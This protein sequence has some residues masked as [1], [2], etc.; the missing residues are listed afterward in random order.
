MSRKVAR[1]SPSGQLISK[2][3]VRYLKRI[4]SDV[5]QN[6]LPPSLEPRR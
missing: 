1:E 4:W 3:P 2:C 6:P 5:L